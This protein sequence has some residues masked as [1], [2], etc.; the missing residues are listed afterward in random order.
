MPNVSTEFLTWEEAAEF[1]RVNKRTLARWYAEGIGPP[2][3][4]LERQVLYSKDSLVEW[5]LSKESKP[6]RA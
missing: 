3:I 1:L 5:L 6:C 4:K 2:R